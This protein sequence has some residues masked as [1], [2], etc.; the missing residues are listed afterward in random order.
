MTQTAPH[1]GDDSESNLIQ[2][3]R[4]H[5]EEDEEL[6][7]WLQRKTDKYTSHE[8]Q[9]RLIQIMALQLIRKIA[10]KIQMSP[11]VTVMI[12]ET[13]DIT[14]KEQVTI[15]I[16]RIDEDL[17]VHEEFLGLYTVSAIDAATLFGVVKDI[18]CRLNL[19]WNKLR[20][21]CYDGCSTMSGSRSGVAKRVQEEEPHAIF[22]HCYSHSL[23]LAANDS[24]K[25]STFMKASLETTH[26]ITKLIK[27]SPR[28]DAIFHELKGESDLS[29]DSKS[30][31]ICLLCPTRWTVRADSL[32]SILN[33]YSTLL[34]T[35]DK[36]K[37]GLQLK[38]S[39]SGVW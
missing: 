9:N 35:W 4:H 28:R 22:T 2:L 10:E 8:I 27:Y 37:H 21:Q 38:D 20:G 7:E 33:N 1:N 34:A 23:N 31:S 12:D 13:T 17:G 39:K 36:T 29:T 16:R 15:V 26:E 14:N 19:S 25:R 30:S 6:L 18:L 11:F 3:L 32:L 24:V 5:G